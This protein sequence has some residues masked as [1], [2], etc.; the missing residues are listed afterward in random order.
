MLYAMCADVLAVAAFLVCCRHTLAVLLQ[1]SLLQFNKAIIAGGAVVLTDTSNLTIK[2]CR[3]INNTVSDR[4]LAGGAVCAVGNASVS[5]SATSIVRSYAPQG[6]GVAIFEN[7]ALL[8]GRNVSVVHNSANAG[9]GFAV[10]SKGCDPAA[11]V[12]SATNN[13]A[14]YSPDVGVLAQSI[15]ILNDTTQLNLTSRLGASEGSTVIAVK[16]TGLYDLP[17]SMDVAAILDGLIHAQAKAAA[18]GVAF[19]KLK[20]M[21]PPGRYTMK[22]TVPGTNLKPATLIIHVVG[23]PLGDVSASSGDACITCVRGSYS[24]NP[25][26]TTCDACP[27]NAGEQCCEDCWTTCIILQTTLRPAAA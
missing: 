17:V 24:L 14:V 23:C 13:T 18:D 27:L 5:M 20:V 16:L 11:L 7:A 1:D 19:L 21:R 4:G 3:F 9:G 25:S 8:L 22:F 6:G 2:G 10:S 15:S 26:N 12:R